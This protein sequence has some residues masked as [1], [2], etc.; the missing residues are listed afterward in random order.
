MNDPITTP[1]VANFF[2]G[3]IGGTTDNTNVSARSIVEDVSDIEVI[4]DDGSDRRIHFITFP[5]VD[6]LAYVNDDGS[7]ANTHHSYT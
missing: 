5:S 6:N 4:N 1:R 3:S 7:T 2:V